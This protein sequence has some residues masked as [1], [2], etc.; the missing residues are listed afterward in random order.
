MLERA[1]MLAI[2][3]STR[4]TAAATWEAMAREEAARSMRF[5]SA[6]AGA[7]ERWMR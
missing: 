7:G 4:E 5:W 2:S 1:A 3:L 6:A